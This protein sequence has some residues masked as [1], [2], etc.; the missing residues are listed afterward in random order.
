MP[1]S[2]KFFLSILIFA[3]PVGF[4]IYAFVVGKFPAKSTYFGFT[5][6]YVVWGDRNVNPKQLVGMRARI[7]AILFFLIF[8]AIILALV[9]QSN[10]PGNVMLN[11]IV[12]IVLGIIGGIL[13]CRKM[14][15]L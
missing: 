5:G 6:N 8:G 3:V 13:L 7:L 14:I 10:L 1:D 15:S 9:S 4:A 12:S 11:D 2:I